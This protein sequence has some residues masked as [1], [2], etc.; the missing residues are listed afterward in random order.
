MARFSAPEPVEAVWRLQP[1]TAQQ[2]AQRPGHDASALGVAFVARVGGGAHALDLEGARPHE[3]GR[4]AVGL[5]QHRTPLS[6]R[7][8]CARRMICG[9]ANTVEARVGAST[10][11]PGKERSERY[12]LQ[13]LLCVC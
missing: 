6:K 10:L 2:Q 11:P 1:P 7:P 4:A 3:A 5:G 13:T 12:G 9:A 8:R